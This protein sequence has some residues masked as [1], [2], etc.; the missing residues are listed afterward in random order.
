MADKQYGTITDFS[1][2]LNATD[3]PTLIN[4]NQVTDCTNVIFGNGFMKKR[5]GYEQY[6]LGRYDLPAKSLYEYKRNDGTTRLLYAETLE[7]G[8]RLRVEYDD[9]ALTSSNSG[10]LESAD[11][12]YL[13]YKD[14]SI[15]DVVLIADGGRLKKFDGATN[16]ISVVAAHAPTISVPGPPAIIG[17][18]VDPGVND[19]AN[20]TNVRCMALKKDRLFLVGHPTV[21]N[22]VHFSW[23]DPIIGYAVY[24]YIPAIYFFDVAT[25]ENDEIVELKVFRNQLIIFCKKSIWALKGDGSSLA[26]LELIKVNVP[27]GCV[28]PNSI[29][30]VGNNIFFLSEDHVYSLFSSDQEYVSA[31]VV[32]ANIKPLLNVYSSV[33]RPSA[34]ATF[35]DNRYWLSFPDGGTFVYDILLECW[36]R[37]TNIK[38][39]SYL[40]RKGQLY[41]TGKAPNQET[42]TV[43]KF[44]E[45]KY[46]DDVVPINYLVRT[47]IYNFGLPINQKKFRRMWT[48]QQQFDGM[49][50]TY[51][52]ECMIDQYLILSVGGLDANFNKNN[53]A[54]WDEAV[55]DESKWD[56]TE[57][58]TNKINVRKK[59]KD[60][61]LLFKNENINE[62]VSIFGFVVEYEVKRPK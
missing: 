55:W 36:T 33:D 54:I 18:D 30:E 24:D 29:V 50:S 8:Y 20:L 39:N 51:T 61:Q 5:N 19:L 49:I 45:N 17:E 60:I 32:S 62:P 59:G 46:R 35:Y 12:R 34:A 53:A 7:M 3:N 25:E 13:T 21:K 14:R 26:D 4:D 15:N 27:T 52:A 31:Q 44:N 1:G 37:F 38:A 10:V 22:R 28:A 11:V 9:G 48:M 6:S 42:Y 58:T 23:I 2:G 43:Y 57:T 47:K 16:T 41:F 40:I 56:F